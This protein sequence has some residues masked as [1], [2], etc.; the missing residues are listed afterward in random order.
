MADA[1]P[2]PPPTRPPAWREYIDE[3]SRN[4]AV[5]RDKGMPVWSLVRYFRIHQGN[6][7]RVLSAYRGDLSR[8]ELDA[9][10]SYYRAKPCAIDEKLAEING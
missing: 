3:E 6:K 8:E 5:I 9:A 4:V 7:Q 2:P 10:L 1:N